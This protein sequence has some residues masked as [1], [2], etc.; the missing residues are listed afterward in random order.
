VVFA[1]DWPMADPAAE[2]AAIRALGL[3]ADETA[4]ILGGTLAGLLGLGTAS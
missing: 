1:T 4:A 2:I 3:G